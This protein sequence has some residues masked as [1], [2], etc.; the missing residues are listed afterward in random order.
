MRRFWFPGISWF[1]TIF[2]VGSTLSR[3][4]VLVRRIRPRLG[5][6]SRRP[7]HLRGLAGGRRPPFH[8]PARA[9]GG[10][11]GSQSISSLSGGSCGCCVLRQQDCSGVSEET[12]RY[13]GSDPQHFSAKDSALGGTAEHLSDAPVCSRSEQC[14]GGRHVSPQSGHRFRAD[15]PSGGV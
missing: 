6:D 9:A 11:E 7:L 1:G 12:G 13:F 10:G 3:P 5:G 2:G 4:N 15:S 8:Q 14:G